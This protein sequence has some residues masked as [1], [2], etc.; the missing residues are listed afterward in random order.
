[1]SSQRPSKSRRTNSEGGRDMSLPPISY[2]LGSEHSESVALPPIRTTGSPHSRDPRSSRGQYVPPPPARM[3]SPPANYGRHPPYNPG[4]PPSGSAAYAPQQTMQPPLYYP[5][6]RP[7]HSA[8]HPAPMPSNPYMPPAPSSAGMGPYHSVSAGYPRAG[9]SHQTAM[10]PPQAGPSSSQHRP[11]NPPTTQAPTSSSEDLSTSGSKPKY[12]CSYCGKG[13][14]R[15]SA[16]KI[17]IISH[18]HVKDFVCPEE[19]CGRRFG[20]RSNML[21][22]IRLVHQ[23]NAQHS[24]GEELSKDEWSEYSE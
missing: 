16:L 13:F 9:P 21:R 6:G 14:L 23:S 24:S 17:H 11:R 5:P 22:H 19:N 10:A 12:E 20:V 18:T 3:A 7:V 8:H 1:M 4:V 15:P 2:V